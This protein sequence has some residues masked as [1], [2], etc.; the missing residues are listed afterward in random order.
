M[1]SHNTQVAK[2]LHGPDGTKCILIFDGTYLFIEKSS[3]FG[4][5]RRTYSVQKHANLIK[6][7]MCVYTDSLI[8]DV[9]GPYQGNTNDATILNELLEK[10]IW[11][12]FGDG[13]VLLVDRGFRDS[14]EK[15]ESNGFIVKM[16]SFSNTP[17]VQLTTQ[18]ANDSRMVTKNR[19]PVE[20]VNGIIKNYWSYFAKTIRN[21]TLKMLFQDFRNVCA[22]YN[23]TFKASQEKSIEVVIAKRMLSL[24][25]NENRLAKFVEEE[26]LN[27]KK[28]IF[29]RIDTSEIVNFPRLLEE[30]LRMY[31]CG[32]YQIRM[33]RSY[34]QKHIQVTGDFAF[35][36]AK[37]STNIDFSKYEIPVLASDA[38]LLQ[39]RVQ[40]RHKRSLQYFTFVLIDSSKSEL[41]AIVRHTCGCKVGLRVVGCC[42]HIATILWYFGY[43]RYLPEVQLPSPHLTNYFLNEM[44]ELQD[45]DDED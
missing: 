17:K 3:N 14:I 15:A 40:S 37:E 11:G 30:Q 18:Q 2:M 35:E 20:Q 5:Q 32:T 10:D 33:V 27:R 1:L 43:A 29:K 8:A 9:F 34:Y 12:E 7:M 38:Q 31:C 45:S 19:W 4:F 42:S 13:D 26:N 39:I 41:H 25:S 36:I 23:M 16:L 24:N 44:D 21:T 22:L 28:P 6:P